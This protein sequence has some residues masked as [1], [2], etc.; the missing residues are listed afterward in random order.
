MPPFSGAGW[1]HSLLA[2][3]TPPPQLRE[4]PPYGL[5]GP[6]RPFTWWEQKPGGSDRGQSGDSRRLTFAWAVLFLGEQDPREQTRPGPQ[7][8][9][10]A[11]GKWRVWQ[12]SWP[13]AFPVHHSLEQGC[14]KGQG[15]E[16]GPK[17]SSHW[18]RRL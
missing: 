7:A 11:Q 14:M 18:R 3:S 1:L 6:Q 4:Q 8:V 10:S 17:A 2:S 5:Q 12:T 9:P 15:L 13:W 16:P